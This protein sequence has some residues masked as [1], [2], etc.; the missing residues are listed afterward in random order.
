MAA[1]RDGVLAQDLGA[2]LRWIRAQRDL[3]QSEVADRAS[4]TTSMV[5]LYETGKT[6]PEI[7]T[8]ERVLD[9]LHTDFEGL[10]KAL[11]M[12]RARKAGT[13]D[14]LT[15]HTPQVPPLSG[16]VRS[17]AERELAAGFDHLRQFME[18]FLGPKTGAE[19]DP[20]A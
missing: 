8:L 3:M 20:G 1:D 19:E 13:A 2:A 15:F 14:T 9:A 16:D 5:S 18:L 12:V 6:L 10:G 17:Q 11:K 4:V 7:S